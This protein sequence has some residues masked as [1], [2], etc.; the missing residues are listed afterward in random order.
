MSAINLEGKITQ[1]N[2]LTDELALLYIHGYEARR[3]FLKE[4]AVLTS[5]L[6][7]DVLNF[8]LTE[9][10]AIRLL[11]KEI[12]NLQKQKFDLSTQKIMQYYV[13]EKEKKARSFNIIL[14]QVGFIGGGTQVVAGIAT[15]A[16]SA[17]YLCAGFGSLNVSHGL[18]NLYE[19]GYYLLFRENRSG[20]TRDAYRAVAQSIGQR[21]NHADL[22][23]AS[24]DLGISAY[25]LFRNVVREDTFRLFRYIN[26]DFVRGWKTMGTV[27]LIAESAVDITTIGGIYI[28]YKN[29]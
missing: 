1:L 15:C 23:Y 6:R 14:K 10:A 8:C 26:S 17:G 28:L 7:Q 21:E 2:R 27:P 9:D 29:E 16:A 11:D 4:I 18:N 20:W 24:V 19:N 3:G 13:F 5:Q 12:N 25:G 22:A